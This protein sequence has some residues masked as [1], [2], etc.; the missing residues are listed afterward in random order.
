[1]NKLRVFLVDDHAAMREGLKLL[2]NAQPDME[3]IGQ[4]GDGRT[5]LQRVPESRPEVVVMDIS[6]PVLNGVQVTEGIKRLYPGVRI[7]ALTRHRDLGYLRQVMQ[8]G[9]SGYVLKQAAA[10]ALVGAIRTIAAG[11]TYLDPELASR[12]MNGYLGRQPSKEV[13][14]QAELSEREVEVIRLIAWGRSNKEI[15]AHLGISVKTVEY[16]KSRAM[17]KLSLHS[18]T[19]IV[20]YAVQQ[21]WLQ[22]V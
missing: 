22:D 1:M 11:G 2:I 7:L 15:A 5:A 21:G 18:R 6:L 3:V 10:D 4:A 12:V 17:E 14:Q 16:H 20:R 19:D 8:A 13:S 9:A